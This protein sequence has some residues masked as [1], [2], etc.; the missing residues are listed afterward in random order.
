VGR[1]WQ[2]AWNAVADLGTVVD[3]VILRA[4]P[5]DETRA[6]GRTV[7]WLTRVHPGE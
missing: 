6:R 7:Y 1:S 3:D 4:T 2:F 5:F